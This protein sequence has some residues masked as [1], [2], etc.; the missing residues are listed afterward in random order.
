L[1]AQNEIGIDTNEAV[2]GVHLPQTKAAAAGTKAHYH[3]SVHTKQYFININK[4]LEFAVKDG[5]PTLEGQR[6]AVIRELADIRRELENG[7]FP[8]HQGGAR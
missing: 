8:I 6:Q 4:R 1:F 5:G 2:N 3:P 7:T